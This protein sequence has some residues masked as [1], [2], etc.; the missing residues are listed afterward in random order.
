MNSRKY[1]E[2]RKYV[3]EVDPESITLLTVRFSAMMISMI[4]WKYLR[5]RQ[6]LQKHLSLSLSPSLSL[7]LS[8]FID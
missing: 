6:L 2:S 5:F 8:L 3:D 4:C 1:P 7:S